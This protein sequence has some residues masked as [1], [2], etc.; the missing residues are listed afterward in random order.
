MK[1]NSMEIDKKL[2]EIIEEILI[3][4]GDVED[5]SAKLRDS[6]CDLIDDLG[7][8]SLLMVQMIVE[9][10]NIFDFNFELNDLDVSKLRKFALLRECVQER[11]LVQRDK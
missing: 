8:N 10:E 3:D 2:K 11:L 5:L 7:L 4:Y 6:Q 1:M 9:V